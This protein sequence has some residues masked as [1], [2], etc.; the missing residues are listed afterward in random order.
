MLH[1]YK[2]RY[3]VSYHSYLNFLD[4]KIEVCKRF[5]KFLKFPKLVSNSCHINLFGSKNESCRAKPTMTAVI[6]NNTVQYTHPFL[7]P[8]SKL[9]GMKIKTYFKNYVQ[10]IKT[11]LYNSLH[12]NKIFCCP[13]SMVSESEAREI[14]QT[15][16]ISP[17][18]KGL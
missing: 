4:E 2:S 15:N 16:P 13:K 14:L 9:D 18:C 10:W 7:F 12:R 17:F 1:I 6:F 11:M 3:E 8:L 5:D